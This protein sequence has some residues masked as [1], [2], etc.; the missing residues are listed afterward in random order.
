M[1]WY[2]TSQS[3]LMAAFAVSGNNSY[4]LGFLS[5]SLPILGILTSFIIGASLYAAIKAMNQLKSEK[6]S[7]LDQDEYLGNISTFKARFVD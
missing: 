1:N 3:F 2:V 7:I 4:R 5:V 6:K